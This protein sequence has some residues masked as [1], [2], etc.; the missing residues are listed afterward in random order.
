MRRRLWSEHGAEYGRTR[1]ASVI[2]TRC[3]P[4]ALR[5][6]PARSAQRVNAMERMKELCDALYVFVLRSDR[7]KMSRPVES[8]LISFKCAHRYQPLAAK[9]LEEL[10]N[11][12]LR[13]CDPVQSARIVGVPAKNAPWRLEFILSSP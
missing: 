7:R 6:A 3:V 9:L 12:A 1:C 10:R 13:C 8:R 2:P 5:I 11:E 4:S